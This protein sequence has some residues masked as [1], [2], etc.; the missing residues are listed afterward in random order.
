MK[1]FVVNNATT[2]IFLAFS[3]TSYPGLACANHCINVIR[4]RTDDQDGHDA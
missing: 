4:C 1:I 3:A 2:E